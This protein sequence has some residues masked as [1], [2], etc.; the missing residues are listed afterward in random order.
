MP[1]I[2]LFLIAFGVTVIAYPEFIAYIIGMLF[3]IVGINS[4]ILAIALR[5]SQNAEKKWSFGNYEIIRK[6]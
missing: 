5:R 3:I 2:P 1:L 6:R 4:F